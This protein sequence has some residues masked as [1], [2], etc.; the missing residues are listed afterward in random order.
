MMRRN[1]DPW[2]HPVSIAVLAVPVDDVVAVPSPFQ[3]LPS[4]SWVM[5]PAAMTGRTAI[6]VT[7]FAS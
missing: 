5:T 7:A 3:P 6:P 1:N 4:K 2:H